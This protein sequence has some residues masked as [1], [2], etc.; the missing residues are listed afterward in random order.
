MRN[1][2]KFTGKILPKCV[3]WDVVYKHLLVLTHQNS[4]LLK[5]AVLFFSSAS[6]TN[7]NTYFFKQIIIINIRQ[8]LRDVNITSLW[9]KWNILPNTRHHHVL[10]RY[11]LWQEKIIFMFK[12]ISMIK[13]NTI[14]KH[15]FS[16]ILIWW[17][18]WIQ[19]VTY[20]SKFKISKS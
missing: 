13:W 3:L 11:I 6:N 14:Y 20:Y 1:F 7:Q 2:Q 10:I 18:C 9:L 4:T 12:N 16:V 19:I 5:S 8:C 15:L 17:S